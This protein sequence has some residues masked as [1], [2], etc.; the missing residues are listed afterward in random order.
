MNPDMPSTVS[1]KPDTDS[2]ESIRS[3]AVRAAISQSILNF[4][5]A[6]QPQRNHITQRRRDAKALAAAMETF[7]YARPQAAVVAV[8]PSAGRPD[9]A[10]ATQ[11][12]E[13]G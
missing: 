8:S 2:P 9:G 4:A 6:K 1:H 10:G 5:Y 12:I 13:H 11:E 3:H 7:F